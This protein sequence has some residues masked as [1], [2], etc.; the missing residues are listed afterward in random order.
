VGLWSLVTSWRRGKRRVGPAR[1]KLQCEIRQLQGGRY[2]RFEAME[3]RRLLD[4]D[5]IKV[6]VTYL[7][8]DSGSDL[9]G[10]TFQVMF[11]GGAPDT[12]LTRLV[13]DGDHYGP[14]R[15]F[16]DMIFDTVKGGLGADEAFPLQVVSSTGIDNVTWQVSDG[17]TS[18]VFQF[19]GFNAGEKLVFSID[20]DEVQIFDPAETDLDAINSGIDP[21]ASGVEFQGSHLTAD[22]HAPHY[23]DINGTSEFRNQYDPL[24]A[25]TNL[26]VTQGNANGLPN[27]N[28]DGKRDRSTGGLLSLQQLPLPVTVGGRVFAD[29]NRN[30]VQDGSDFGISG[31]SM[32]LWKKVNGQWTFT[33]NTTTTN[34]QGDYEFG[35]SLNL[36]P[37]EYEVRET[38]PAGYFSVGAIPGTVDGAAAGST[39]PG[40]PDVLTSIGLPLGDQHGIHYNF[41]EAQPASLRG[42]VELTDRNGNCGDENPQA[43]TT[44]LAGV[45]ITLKDGQGNIVGTTLT[46]QDGTYAFEN[47]MPG[48][49]TIV[50]ETPA[51]LID[52]DEHIGTING[53]PVG[54]LS[55]DDTV[56]NITLNGGQDGVHYDFCEHL[57]SSVS[58]Y[59]YHDANNNGVR[60]SGETPIGGTTVILLDAGGTQIATTTTDN[61]GFYKF[62]NLSAGTYLIREVQPSSW[63]D[64]KDA[65]GT[66]L[67][68]VVGSAQNPGDQIGGVKLLWGDDGINY[69]FGELLPASI[70]GHVHESPDGNCTD[71]N[72]GDEK[73]IAGVTIQLLD[74]SGNVVRTTTTDENGEYEFTNLTPGI[75][76]V[77][78]IQPAGYLQGD[79]HVGSGGGD[80]SVTDLLKNIPIQSGDDLV[81][82]DFCEMLPASIA[83]V[84][85]VDT[86]Q[87]CELDE[88][89]VRL[90]G[91]TIQL[92]NANGQVVATRV[93]AAD[94]SYRFDNLRPGTYSIRE[95]QPVG[96]FEG[97]THAGSLGGDDSMQ[98]NITSIVTH[99][100]DQGINYNFGELPAGMIS[101]YV[102][103]D[104]PPIPT[105]DGAVPDNLYQIRDGQLTPDDL[106]LRGVTLELRYTLT[107]EPVRGED[108]LPGTY[109]PGPVRTVTNANGY[110]EFRGLPQG[111][112]SIFEVQP[113]GYIDSQDTPGTTSGLAVNVGTLVSPLV[114]QTFAVAG[115]S[116]HNDAILQVP[117]AF[118]QQ[119]QFNNFSEVQVVT[120]T[121]VPP[122]PETPE[123]P[124]PVVQP[125]LLRFPPPAPPPEV[126]TPP[127]AAPIVTGGGGEF[128][129]HLS[130]IDAGLPRVARRST[131][132]SG[133]A[134][135]PALWIEKTEWQSDRLRDGVW[136]VHGASDAAPHALF[137]L[138]GA[139][140]V[141]G[142]F[143]GDGRDEVGVFY[144]GEWFLDLN[145]NGQWDA[146]DL[147]AKLG[148]E[149]DRPVSGDWDGDGK[150]DIGIFGPKWPGDPVHLEHEAG[151]PDQDNQRIG[152]VRAKNVPPNPEE[153]TDGE[154]LLR[155]TAH[156]KERADLIDHVFQFGGSNDV[157]IA[158]DW[159]GDGIRSVGVFRD[160][161]WHFDMDGDGR[162]SDGDKTAEFGQKGDIPVV[163]DF[164]GDGIEEIA[165]FRAGKWIIDTNGNRQI[166]P[167]DRTLDFGQAGDKPIAGDFDG[168]GIDEP[169]IFRPGGDAQK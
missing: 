122:P 134:F 44:P 74:Q 1:Q 129:W 118:G 16:G 152:K 72:E 103:R 50:E 107:G 37:G 139:I 119:S 156:G 68:Q 46:A 23:H 61:G 62:A 113:N 85:W 28:F 112:Y 133:L 7:E 96:Y 40:N 43:Q 65:A 29:N 91:V 110:Y 145:G 128:T 66:I 102:F 146:E 99:S 57:P 52:G 9:H 8:G 26:L 140:P 38:Q 87:N 71:G 117:L 92:L 108:L 130:V 54:V 160:G 83:G 106:R 88:G 169:A 135:R 143:N 27:D 90:G 109:P 49:Y 67:G 89:E 35:A 138:P 114:V 69:D 59:V 31:V 10:D 80:A 4:A 165:I 22:F 82:Y 13:I 51:G 100:G 93:T 25:G 86:T 155:L 42:R 142:D 24:F 3:E 115:V 39:V 14:G 41:A 141:V 73:P 15:S 168:D 162:W 101:G 53:V 153:A 18:L 94:G 163:G 32:A 136:L 127:P 77:H 79:Q 144:K 95:I 20:V 125:L 105:K 55:A 116:F 36:Q 58:G 30:L 161:K 158:G 48:V 64:G 19:R 34:A 167:S 151:L 70:R 157:P 120:T 111:N 137:G 56:S 21:I 148:E 121:I 126:F 17:G 47:L 150:D 164:N 159:N 76:A 147:W 123:P 98:D 97:C 132:I 84:V 60:D 124:P 166:D 5:P 11:Q 33:G 131:R 12:E 2:C 45:K 104:G 63:L 81:D 78:E 149:Q 75:Y 6:G 154:R